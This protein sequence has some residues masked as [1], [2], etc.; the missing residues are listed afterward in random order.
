MLLSLPYSKVM[1]YIHDLEPPTILM[2]LCLE[3]VT[4][5]NSMCLYLYGKGCWGDNTTAKISN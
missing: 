1:L 2:V 4:T 5:N 3:H